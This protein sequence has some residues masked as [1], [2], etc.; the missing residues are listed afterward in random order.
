ML[1]DAITSTGVNTADRKYLQIGI[2]ADS[3]SFYIEE[4][5]R[6]DVEGPKNLFDQ[7]MLA[8]WFAKMV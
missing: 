5:N 1:E 2:N 7:T 6:Y 8:D 3:Q 4:Q